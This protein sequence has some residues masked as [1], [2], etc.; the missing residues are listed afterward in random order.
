MDR[1]RRRFLVGGAATVAV[2]GAAGAGLVEADVLPGRARLHAALG[3]D[4]PDG[5]IPDV[6]PGDRHD[7]VLDVPDG[8]ARLGWSVVV[9][10]GHELTDPLPVIVALHGRGGD[11]DT[12]FSSLGLDRF[13]AQ[14]VADGAPPAAIASIDGGDTYWHRRA[15]GT[16]RGAAVTDLLVPALDELGMDTGRLAFFGWSMGGYGSLLLAGQLGPDVVRAV[17]TLSAALWT[18]AADAADG[19]FDDAADFDAQDVFAR[20]DELVDIPLRMDCGDDDPF[21]AA[22]VAYRTSFPGTLEGGIERGAHTVGYWR[23][24]APDQ[25]R[26]LLGHL[27]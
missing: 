18:R 22:N 6:E 27:A 1:S 11:H 23:R 12:A 15:D 20:Q 24:M 7:A 8:T 14:A 13:L 21:E 4:G 17:G 10:P 2:V 9:P 3:L 16:D 26:F 25:L 19:A 5:T